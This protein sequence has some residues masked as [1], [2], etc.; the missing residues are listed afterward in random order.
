M[1]STQTWVTLFYA[2]PTVSPARLGGRPWETHTPGGSR[3][4]KRIDVFISAIK[5]Y[6]HPTAHGRDL[7]GLQKVALSRQQRAFP[8]CYLCLGTVH[9][10]IFFLKIYNRKRYFAFGHPD[11]VE[12]YPARRWK[13]QT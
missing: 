2:H 7:A 3:G 10:L 4:A 8:I 11:K 1:Y 5:P 12:L 9:I 6:L 13:V